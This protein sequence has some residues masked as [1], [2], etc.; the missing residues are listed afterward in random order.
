MSGGFY[1][2]E[3]MDEL[4]EFFDIDREIVTYRTREEL[5]DKIRFYLKN[6]TARETIRQA[7]HKRALRDHTW[8]RRF[9]MVFSRIGLS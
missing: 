4:A 2:V 9:E 3:H 6:E 7:G 1:L 8:R 5:A